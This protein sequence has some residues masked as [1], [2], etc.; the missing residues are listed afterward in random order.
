MDEQGRAIPL[1]AHTLNKVGVWIGGSGLSDDVKFKHDP[2][3]VGLANVTATYMNLLGFEA[4]DFYKTTL[5]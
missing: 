1:T 5:L 3:E 4:P 2:K